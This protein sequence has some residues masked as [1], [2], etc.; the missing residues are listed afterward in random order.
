V[1]KGKIKERQMPIPEAYRA[2]QL[3]LLVG[4]NP[5]PNW[6]AAQLLI[7]DGGTF[8][9]IYSN[10]THKIAQRLRDRLTG[11]VRLLQVNPTD[12]EDIHWQLHRHLR[13]YQGALGLHYTGGTK[14][15]AVH[16]YQAVTAIQERRSEPAVFSYLD[17]EAFLLRIDP[18]WKEPVLFEVKPQLEDLAALHGARLRKNH[19]N[20][21]DK[22]WG[23]NTAKALA[24]TA[25]AG[26]LLAWQCWLNG[27]FKAFADANTTSVAM[28]DDPALSSVRQGL[29]QDLNLPPHIAALPRN[30]IDQLKP[31][32]K[33]FNGEWLEH[34]I[35]DQFLQIASATRVH[36]CGMS[37][38]TD[39][40]R[41]K[42]D[43]DFEFDV[44]AMRGYQFFGLSC[45]TN[46]DKDTAKQKLFE[47][48]IRARQLGGDEARVGLVCAYEDVYSFEQQILQS[49]RAKGRIKVFG[50]EIWP[51]LA[52]HLAEW[53]ETAQ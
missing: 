48:Y 21:R 38:A 18:N 2:D 19:P 16:T 6:I 52:R 43:F 50:P 28:P 17:A 29:Y 53:L 46:S 11:D 22:L 15:M 26:N 27:L 25:A 31:K 32:T 33:W 5:L 10:E 35:L 40:R 39:Q 3:I 47:A 42:S 9:L 14:A 24:V 12:A 13:A 34:Y 41:G 4:E 8:H 37:L 1:L 45:T 23:L 7:K 36:D 30:V 44:A 51:E 20:R 49:W